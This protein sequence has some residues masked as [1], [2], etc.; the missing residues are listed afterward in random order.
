VTKPRVALTT[1]IG[2]VI[3]AVIG[4]QLLAVFNRAY[5][6]AYPVLLVLALGFAIGCLAGP[7]ACLVQMTSFEG[8]YLPFVVMVCV[9]VLSLQFAP[10]PQH[11]VKE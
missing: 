7:T 4:D 5:G 8:A 10:V 6:N 2:F 11:D 9:L 3:R 1:L